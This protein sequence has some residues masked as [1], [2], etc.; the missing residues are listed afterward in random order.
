MPAHNNLHMTLRAQEPYMITASFQRYLEQLHRR[1]AT[2]D[3]GAVA[4]YIPELG[5]AD[6]AWFG[7]A[8]VTVDGHVYQ[9]GDT[10]QPFSIQSISKPFTYGIALED[11]GAEIVSAKIDVEPSGEA[12]NSI[13]LEPGTGRPRNPMINAGAI[14]ATSLV[15]GGDGEARLGRILEKFTRYAGRPLSV[16]E[17]IYLSE[18]HTGHRNR[19]IAH[20]LR[21]YEILEDDPE[22]PL[23]A[24]F[25]QCSILVTARDLALMGATLANDGVNPVTGIRA[26]E[27]AMVPR[28]LS[29]MATCGMYDYSGNWIYSVGMPAKSGVGGGVVAV[30]PGQL[31]LAVFSPRL[32]AK[33]N[34][35]RGIAVCEALSGDFGLHMLRVT[36]TTTSSVIRTSYTCTSVRSKLNRD[37]KSEAFLHEAGECILVMELTGELMFVPAEIVATTALGQMEARDYLILDLTRVTAVDQSAATLLAEVLD[38]LGKQGKTVMITGAEHHYHFI[39]FLKRYFGSTGHL[40]VFD[41]PDVDHALE[42]AEDC[43]LD[44]SLLETDSTHRVA[45]EEQP[46]CR[47]F[48]SGEL[49]LLRS[50]LQE[51]IFQAGEVICREGEPAD[52]LYFLCSGRVSISLELDHKHRHRLSASTA[53]WAFGESALF[54][55]HT[56]TADIRTDTPVHVY[57]LYPDSLKAAENPM[58]TRV[59]L[60]LLRNLSELSLARLERANREIKILTR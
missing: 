7:I 34:S 59:M 19:A 50:L 21:N 38:E 58:A 42:H 11:K 25:R 54:S 28:V 40:P 27:S 41:Y 4:D 1:F 45:L 53:G 46:L 20:L 36:R 29:V 39:R 17:D 60:K 31:G 44:A 10:R 57:S 52:K 43:L 32:D 51:E 16:D 55:G 37:P 23:D 26:L 12:F 49:E 14:V 33:G 2:L 48:D 9:A 15:D 35:V 18:K 3:S 47:N 8:I 5:K 24:Y 6:P 56:R 13:S 22:E 30:L